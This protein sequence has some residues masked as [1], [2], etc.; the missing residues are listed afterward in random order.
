MSSGAIPTSTPPGLQVLV[1]HD[2]DVVGCGREDGAVFG[3]QVVDLQAGPGGA[4]RPGTGEQDR[5][6]GQARECEPEE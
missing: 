5:E 1:E 3:Q 4:R 2:L 6:S